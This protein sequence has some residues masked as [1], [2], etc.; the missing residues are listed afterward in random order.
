MGWRCP[1]SDSS[2]LDDALVAYLLADATLQG[3][4]PDGVFWDEARPGATRFVIVS[5]V[6]EIDVAEFQRR[7]YEDALYLV[8]AVALL[9]G[10]G[11]V[12]SAAARIDAL[13]EDPTGLAATGY[14]MMTCHRE[15]RVRITE[16]DDADPKVRWQHR[17]GRYRVQ[18][19]L[20]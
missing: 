15:S 7:A 9:S 16:V 20:A 10:G 8:K 5:L 11:N 17:G 2:A 6:D 18:A 1:V 12:K 3:L 13:L 14:G 19:A 4:M